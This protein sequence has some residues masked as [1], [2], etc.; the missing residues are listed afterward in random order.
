MTG[1]TGNHNKFNAICSWTITN[2][3]SLWGFRIYDKKINRSV[4]VVVR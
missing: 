1:D 4:W 2:C 3:T